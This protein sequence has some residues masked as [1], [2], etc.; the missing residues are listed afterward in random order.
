MAHGSSTNSSTQA[1]GNFLEKTP[2]NFTLNLIFLF[3]VSPPRHL[4]LQSSAPRYL[5]LVICT[6]SHLHLQ[7]SAPRH[8]HHV[9]CTCSH[10]HLAIC[11]TSSAPRHLHRQS[12]APRHLH[13][14]VCT[15]PRGSPPAVPKSFQNMEQTDPSLAAYILEHWLRAVDAMI[16]QTLNGW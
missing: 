3:Y 13:L 8:L 9:I 16:R 1:L 12:F 2:Y 4:H 5:H 7:S 6:C 11:T 10:L 14:V 15:S